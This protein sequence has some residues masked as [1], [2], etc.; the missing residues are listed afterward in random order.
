MKEQSPCDE[1]AEMLVL[2]Q[3]DLTASDHAALEAHL[4]HCS[5][6]QVAQKNYNRLIIRIHELPLS[7]T[8]TLLDLRDQSL[9]KG[10]TEEV[11]KQE[12]LVSSR[13]PLQSKRVASNV[14]DVFERMLASGLSPSIHEQVGETS[15]ESLQPLKEKQPPI[16]CS[17]KRFLRPVFLGLLALLIIGSFWG[18]TVIEKNNLAILT[19]G[20]STNTSQHSTLTPISRATVGATETASNSTHLFQSYHGTLEELS[21]NVPSPM[22][23]T[24]VRQNGGVISGYF[25]SALMRG[26]YNGYLDRS[27]HIYF[28]VA[29]PTSATPLYFVGTVQSAGNIEGSFCTIDQNN[30]CISGDAY[31]VWNV[32][33]GS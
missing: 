11:K 31:G 4:E 24:H 10:E 29:N 9:L 17:R 26:N 12:S 20:R 14:V 23:L 1:W 22:T 21:T 32:V 16:Q 2:K 33:P 25:T 15:E 18:F 8:K 3:E 6:C 30:Q 7:A 19:A 13:L 28:T 5:A 27:K